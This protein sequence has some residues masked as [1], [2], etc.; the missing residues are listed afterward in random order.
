[1][2]LR[3]LDIVDLPFVDGVLG[4]DSGGGEYSGVSSRTMGRFCPSH[5]IDLNLQDLRHTE[6]D[7]ADAWK[8]LEVFA[9]DFD[10]DL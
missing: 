2:F 9:V 5:Q 3:L 8:C 1:M 4:L 10:S 7:A 6:D